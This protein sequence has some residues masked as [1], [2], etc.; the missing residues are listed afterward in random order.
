MRWIRAN[1]KITAWCAFF[2]LAVQLILSFGHFHRNGIGLG[3]ISP[4]LLA[5]SADQAIP[6]AIDAS[7]G[8]SKPTVPA[9]VY[10]GV[11]A[12]VNLA[13][14]VV[15]PATPAVP[16]PAVDSCTLAWPIAE[17]SLTPPLYLYAQARAPPQA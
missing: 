14:S 6:E 2:A 16:L 4:S 17:T 10:C 8:P 1:L 5:S 11:C 9:V 3:S 15:P 13:G 7:G 12:V